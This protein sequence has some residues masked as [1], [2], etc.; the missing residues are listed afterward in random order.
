M[1]CLILDGES[2]Y[3]SSM[4]IKKI[5]TA[6]KPAEPA[7]DAAPVSGTAIADR[8]RLDI[9]DPS[10][11]KSSSGGIAAT[12]AGI[13]GFIALGVAGILTFVI[14]QHWEFLKGA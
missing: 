2:W 9:Q 14:Y 4:T 10:E 3:N 6:P 7:A 8:F 13:A 11:K 1:S 12:I 5:K